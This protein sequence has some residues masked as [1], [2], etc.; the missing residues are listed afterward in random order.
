MTWEKIMM[1]K[2]LP[3]S[4]RQSDRYF[5]VLPL[6]WSVISHGNFLS[7]IPLPRCFR[8]SSLPRLYRKECLSGRIWLPTVF[9]TTAMLLSFYQTVLGSCLPWFRNS[10]CQDVTSFIFYP[11]Y[12]QISGTHGRKTVNPTTGRFMTTEFPNSRAVVPSLLRHP[13]TKISVRAYLN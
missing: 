12:F 13:E 6:L 8:C 9:K 4:V 7:S 3:H 10:L 11:M 2:F 5:G 1:E